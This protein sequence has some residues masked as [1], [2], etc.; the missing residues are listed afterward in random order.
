MKKITCCLLALLLFLLPFG[1]ITVLAITQEDG[2]TEEKTALPVVTGTRVS[3]TE[4]FLVRFYFRLPDG[5]SDPYA[6]VSGNLCEAVEAGEPGLYVATYD[7]FSIS[8][9]TDF[10]EMVPV[11]I[12]DNKTVQG[13]SYRFSVRDYAMRLLAE[14]ALDPALR[15]VLVSMLNFGAAAQLYQEKRV[16]NLANDYLSAADKTVTARDYVSLYEDCGQGEPIDASLFMLSLAVTD[17]ACLK[18]YV[19]LEGQDR[20]RINGGEG[21]AEWRYLSKEMEAAK[22]AEGV[23]VEVADNAAFENASSFPLEKVKSM[24][25]YRVVTSGIYANRYSSAYYLR[26]CTAEGVGHT[27]RYSVESYVARNLNQSS[28]TD[29]GRRMIIAMIEYGDAVRAYH[30]A[31]QTA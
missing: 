18:L 27:F 1:D 6:Y 26:L 8:G 28:M 30:E 29:E 12:V 16:H 24:D 19:N 10:V 11:C 14:D 20:L 15:R 4:N 25:C 7:A 31:Q 5:G 2:E 9:M 21:F 13:V 23:W 3:I 22:L 17:S